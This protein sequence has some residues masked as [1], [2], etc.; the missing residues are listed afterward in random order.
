MYTF[1]IVTIMNKNKL[2]NFSREKNI[3]F[4]IFIFIFFFEKILCIIGLKKSS[5]KIILNPFR[6][7]DFC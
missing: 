2:E 1:I 6:P 7:L 3:S 5:V 4:L